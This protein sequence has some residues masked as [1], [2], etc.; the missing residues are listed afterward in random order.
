MRIK[1]YTPYVNN[2]FHFLSIFLH[3]QRKAHQHVFRVFLEEQEVQRHEGFLVHQNIADIHCHEALETS[4]ILSGVRGFASE[5]ALLASSASGVRGFAS[6]SALLASPMYRHEALETGLM[7]SGVR[8]F[9]Q[10]PISTR[11]APLL[12][13]KSNQYNHPSQLVVGLFYTKLIKALN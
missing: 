3:T 9:A 13:E 10:S 5:S 4:L 12:C 6:E 11:I 1:K 7:L 2:N 8:G